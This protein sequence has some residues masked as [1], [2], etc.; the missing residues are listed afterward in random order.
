MITEDRSAAVRPGSVLFSS[1]LISLH[2][3]FQ[4]GVDRF[5][6]CVSRQIIFSR[7]SV[8]FMKCKADKS[9]HHQDASRYHQPMRILHRGPRLI[10]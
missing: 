4:G 8:V 6:E 2:L 5:R 7:L 3:C 10:F 9:E 1:P